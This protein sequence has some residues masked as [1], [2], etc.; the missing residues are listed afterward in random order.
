[1]KLHVAA[2]LVLVVGAD[3][4]SAQSGRIALDVKTLQP[5]NVKVESVTFKGRQAIRVSDV[6]PADAGDVGRLAVLDTLQ[7]RDGVIEIDLA[8]EPGANAPEAARGFVGIAFRVTPDR[9]RFECFYLRPT[10]GRADDQ[11]RRNHSVQYISVPGFPWPRLR[12]EFPEKYESYADLAPGEW[13]KVRIEV[14]GEKARLYV[15][16]AEQ[17]ALVVNDLKQPVSSG[18]IA[19][20][21]DR[22]TVAHFADLRVS[23]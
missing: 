3:L 10:N 11:V 13:T 22:G 6:A 15:G 18:G 20:W 4:L 23:N 8:G 17:P 5:H 9:S 2:G 21:L 1:M 7:F 12:T 16:G 14:R 19:L